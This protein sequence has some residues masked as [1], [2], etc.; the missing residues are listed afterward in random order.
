MINLC[1][2]NR[3]STLSLSLFP[4]LLLPL[5]PLLSPS[6]DDWFYPDSW[7]PPYVEHAHSLWTVDLV[8]TDRH[9]I[10]LHLVNIH[11]DF[12]YSLKIT[13]TSLIIAQSC[14]CSNFTCAASVWKNTF[15][16]LH[17]SPEAEKTTVK[18]HIYVRDK[19]T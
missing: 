19:F 12:P 8:T 1:L 9:Q 14:D 4:S 13:M 2:H 11:R 6:T 5:S 16:D 3:E 7:S 15:F 10:N 18:R 17:S